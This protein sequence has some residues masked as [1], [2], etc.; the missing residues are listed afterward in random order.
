MNK[1]WLGYLSSIL[2][3][4]AG[5]LLIAGKETTLGVFFIVVSLIGIVLK[6]VMNKKSKS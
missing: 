1:S 2:I 3:L 4:I 5:I 6:V